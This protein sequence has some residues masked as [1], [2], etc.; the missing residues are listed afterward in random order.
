MGGH[1]S[2]EQRGAACSNVLDELMNPLIRDI[3]DAPFPVIAAVNGVA[4]GGGVGL[5]MAADIIIA[6]RS[7]RF[8]LT[9][10]SKLGLVPDLGTSW[11]LAHRLGRARALGVT[12]T[13]EPISAEQALA[14]GMIWKM[15][16][17]A[18]ARS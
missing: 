9:F 17:D 12:L 5:A 8:V 16:E 13:G 18:V 15:V 2:L 3:R 4:A 10:T 14:W 6:A 7:A 1:L 11:Q